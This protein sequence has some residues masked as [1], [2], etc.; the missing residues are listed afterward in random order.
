[1]HFMFLCGHETVTECLQYHHFFQDGGRTEV[2][3]LDYIVTGD[4]V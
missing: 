3:F 4:K 2:E 1:M